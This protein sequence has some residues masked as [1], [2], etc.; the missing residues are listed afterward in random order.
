MKRIIALIMSILML[1][2]VICTPVSAAY[3][4]TD[5]SFIDVPTDSWYHDAVVRVVEEG[6]FAGTSGNTFSPADTMTRAMIAT[7]MVKL[8]DADVDGY[9][10]LPF[11]DVPAGRWYT[12]AVA[13]AHEN[14]LVAGIGG[15]LFDPKSNIT[16]EQLCVILCKFDEMFGSGL[17]PVYVFIPFDDHDDIASW[18]EDSVSYLR[19]CGVAYPRSGNVYSPEATLSRAEVAAMLVPFS[20]DYYTKVFDTSKRV[21]GISMTKASTALYVSDSERLTVSLTPADADDKLINWT[22]SN[23]AVA[24]VTSDGTVTAMGV[25]DA[26]ITA[27]ARDGGFKASCKV[28]VTLPRVS[29]ITLSKASGELKVGDTDKLYATVSPWNA[30]DKSVSWTS[31]APHVASVSADGTVTALSFGMTIITARTIDGGY[32]AS[33]TYNVVNERGIDPTRP[34]VAIT[35]DDGPCKNTNRILDILEANGAVATFF[36]VGRNVN[37]YPDII[38]RMVAMG[39]E[40]G[41]HSYDHPQLTT[42]SY[43]GIRSQIDRTNQAF[44]NAVGFAPSLCR[45]PYG[46][47]N[48]AVD[49]AVNMPMILWSVDTLDWKS[50]NANSVYNVT[51]NNTR[52]GSIV[53]MHSLYTT[54]ADALERILPALREQGYQ[55]VTVSELAMYRGYTLQNAQ[56]YSAFY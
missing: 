10:A 29:S 48:S 26:V 53:L 18:A 5:I 9:N 32:T 40:I 31:S 11:S 38:Q 45:P 23:P 25:G 41:N 50:R 36:E 13:W 15:G 2:A 1:A 49:A 43:A 42:L 3:T 20:G 30:G 14:G 12:K 22:T 37:S 56:R 8:A 46:S 4:D 16:R 39:N 47:R 7:V 33:C 54:T 28:N 34:M 44:I 24:A 51:M 19:M 27:T 52:D 55:F 17:K 6:Y 35:F 21:M